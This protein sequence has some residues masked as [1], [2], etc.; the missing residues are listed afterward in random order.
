M[1]SVVSRRCVKRGTFYNTF[2]SKIVSKDSNWLFTRLDYGIEFINSLIKV[3]NFL[4]IKTVIGFC[5]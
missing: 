4:L 2:S 3:T 5:G 1:I